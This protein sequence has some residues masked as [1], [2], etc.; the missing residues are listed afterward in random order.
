MSFERICLIL[1]SF[2]S[3]SVATDFL[4]AVSR[5]F[6]K[7]TQSLLPSLLSFDEAEFL[8]WKMFKKSTESSPKSFSNVL[9][10]MYRGMFGWS[11]VFLSSFS[12]WLCQSTDRFWLI[13]FVI[14]GSVPIIFL[15][16][17]KKCRFSQCWCFF[18]F[19]IETAFLLHSSCKR[20]YSTA[21]FFLLLWIT[22]RSKW[23]LD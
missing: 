11:S 19:R 8:G 4:L 14:N 21:E 6:Q 18:Y 7:S 9:S 16:K 22:D 20:E 13:K 3:A 17:R 23:W 2:L 10:S 15:G 12:Q 5:T 1:F